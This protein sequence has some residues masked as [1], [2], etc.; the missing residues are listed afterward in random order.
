M[1]DGCHEARFDRHELITLDTVNGGARN[2][3]GLE[4]STERDNS[5]A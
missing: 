2:A 5:I 1:E 4:R 3:K